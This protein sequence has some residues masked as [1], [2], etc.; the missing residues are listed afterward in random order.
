MAYILVTADRPDGGVSTPI[1]TN[2]STGATSRATT[3]RPS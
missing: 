3:S 1:H 2:A